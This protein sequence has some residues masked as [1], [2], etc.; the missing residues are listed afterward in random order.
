MELK[1]S[2]LDGWRPSDYELD[3]IIPI[4]LG[5]AVL[6]RRNLQLQRWSGVCN[7]HMN[8][9]LER[10]LS[11]MVC[12]GDAALTGAVAPNFP[13]RYRIVLAPRSGVV[14]NREN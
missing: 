13:Y 10:Q 5:G 6:D 1:R 7:A 8:D 9:E 14:Y 3:H 4:G 2:L 12:A 11:I